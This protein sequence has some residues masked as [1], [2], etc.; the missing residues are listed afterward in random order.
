[1]YIPSFYIYVPIWA[2]FRISYL[3]I[4]LI[5]CGFREI[6]QKGCRN[7]LV[8][9]KITWISSRTVKRL[10]IIEVE[11]FYAVDILHYGVYHFQYC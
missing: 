7:L 8:G 6:R 11:N 2:K 3:H 4:I 9:I 5:I 1:M 10:E